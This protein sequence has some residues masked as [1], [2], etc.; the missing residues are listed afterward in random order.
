ML[1]I[2]F[3]VIVFVGKTFPTAI[4][5]VLCLFLMFGY[6]KLI[7]YSLKFCD[8]DFVGT[9]KNELPQI[10]FA[11]FVSIIFIVA[12]VSQR[13]TF[14]SGIL[15]KLGNNVCTAGIIF[16]LRLQLNQF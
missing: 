9:L 4:G 3:L 15:W 6:Y 12:M 1:L 13:Q 10:L 7:F 16:L 14:I 8:I 11:S 2:F 5:T